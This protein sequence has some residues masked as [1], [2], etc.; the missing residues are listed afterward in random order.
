VRLEPPPVWRARFVL[1]VFGVFAVVLCGR[2]F[3]LQVLDREFLVEEGA[4]RHL[5]TIDVPAGRGAI[6]D[7]RGEPLALSAPTESVWTVPSALLETPDKIAPLAR[8]LEMDPAELRRRLVE[9]RDRQ[10]LYLRRQLSPAQAR[11]VM[12]LEA[13]GVFLQREYR[14]YYPAGEAAAQLVGL[15]DIDGRGQEGLELALDGALHGEAG[16][17]RVIKDRVG[18]V[19]EDLAEFTPPQAGRD[20]RLSVD[21]RLQYLAYRELKTAVLQNQAEAGVVVMLDPATGGVLALVS[22]P[23]FNPNSRASIPAAGLR[24]RAVTDIFEPGSTIKPL[25]VARALDSGAYSTASVIDTEGG[26]YRVGRLTVHDFRDYGDVD[27]ARLL[28]KSSNVGA[29]KIGLGLG[30][31]ILWDAYRDFGLGGITGVGFPGERY[32]VLRDFYQWGEIATATAAYGYGVSVTAL[33]LAR[34]YAALAADG[35]LRALHLVAEDG[36]GGPPPVDSRAASAGAARTVR[37][38][39]RGVVT[40]EGTASQASVSGYHV[41]GKTGTVRKVTADGYARDRHQALFV[42]MAPA[43]APR[44]VTLVMIDEPRGDTYYGGS[45]AAPVFA[46]IMRDALRMLRVPPDAPELLT[47]DAGSKERS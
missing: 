10:F 16:S 15:T 25:L 38:L 30:P 13:P 19:V 26:D 5:R 32:G 18:R 43:D 21:L 12:G 35:R 1:A 17:R 33:Q 22:Y 39:L 41:A 9:Y 31:E 46:R 37:G 27:L 42:G 28:V 4:K 7:R 34:A 20:I 23:S 44:L 6:R 14:R 29:A 45:V 11:R 47:V 8:R 3:E 40:P 2:A 36:R 24:N